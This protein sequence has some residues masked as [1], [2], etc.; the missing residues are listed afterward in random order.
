MLFGST[1][2]KVFFN[3]R[4]QVRY[5]NPQNAAGH[6]DTKRFRNQSLTFLT[7]EMLKHMGGINRGDRTFRKLQTLSNIVDEDGPVPGYFEF[8]RRQETQC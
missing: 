4:S 2:S 7:V 8:V 1:V 6:K 3:N 5:D